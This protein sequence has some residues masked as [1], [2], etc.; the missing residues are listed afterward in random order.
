M[1]NFR[2]AFL[3]SLGGLLGGQVFQISCKKQYQTHVFK[4]ACIRYL[5][6]PEEIFGAI[7][8]HV[9]PFLDPKMGPKMYPQFVKQTLV[10]FGIHFWTSF[11][12]ISRAISGVKMGQQLVKQRDQKTGPNKITKFGVENGRRVNMQV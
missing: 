3:G 5:K 1:G 4:I 2:E 6:A 11:V 10:Y 7:C 9:V 12:Q 8:A